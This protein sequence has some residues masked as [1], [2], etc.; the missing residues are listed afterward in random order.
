M[1]QF[2][3]VANHI[4]EGVEDMSSVTVIDLFLYI[5]YTLLSNT[6]T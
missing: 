5:P 1:Q 6:V 3:A 4:G 2:S